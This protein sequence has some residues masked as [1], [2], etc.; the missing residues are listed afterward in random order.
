MECK[1]GGALTTLRGLIVPA[2]WDE[3]GNII[4]AAISTYSEEDY[5]IDQ[6]PWGDE[7]LAFVRQKAKVSGVVRQAKDGKKVVTVKAYE[8]LEE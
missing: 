8:I 6:N 7:L 5:L 4:A 2:N 1:D 3:R